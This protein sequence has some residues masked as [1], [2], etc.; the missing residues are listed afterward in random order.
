MHRFRLWWVFPFV[1][2]ALGMVVVAPAVDA[3]TPNFKNGCKST[4][5]PGA[6]MGHYPA[7]PGS[8]SGLRVACIL[9]H[10]NV[11]G[12][13]G[14]FVSSTFTIH[15]FWNALYHNGAGRTMVASL[16][17][18]PGA[19]SFRVA[20]CTSATGWLNRTISGPGIAPYAF[21][22]SITA[23]CD[24]NLNVPIIAP[25]I[26]VGDAFLVE[27]S[28]VRSVTTAMVQPASPMVCD[29]TANFTAAD[30]TLSI[31]GTLIAPG[32]TIT[33]P[34]G[35][36]C[37]D[38][39]TPPTAAAPN[40]LVTIGTTLDGSFPAPQAVTTTRTINDAMFPAM[41]Q[42]SSNAARFFQSDV[43]L[44]VSST[45][46]GEITQPCY[47][48]T[49]VSALLVTLSS[50]CN[51]GVPGIHTVTIG[52]PSRTAPTSADT[53]LNYG[54]Q[55]PLDPTL[56][57]GV[58]PCATDNAG[59]FGVE[60]SWLNPGS[61]VGGVFA[62]QPPGTR[63]V[64]EILFT[65][66]LFQFGAY[67]LEIPAGG[68]VD[69]LVFP[70]HFNVVFPNLPIASALCPSSPTSPGV[71]FSI[72]INATTLSQGAIKTGVGRPGTTQLRSTRGPS[73][74]GSNTTVFITD[75]VNG[76]GVK[77]VGPDFQRTCIIPATT[78]DINF[79]CGDG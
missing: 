22:T 78:P 57:T 8:Q 77:W 27:N 17:S 10:A 16:A 54:V 71:G 6:E 75:D 70:Y 26:G 48:Q 5:T 38:I 30:T 60:G 32:T 79:V 74:I 37:V 15:D 39:S 49:R 14:D 43:G 73:G 59:G 21:V 72:G 53:V 44:R 18:P 58:Q 66:P 23:A 69:P 33:G 50:G 55:L 4:T 68:V 65:T 34:S 47:I 51:N 67:V 7:W 11:A 36:G 52:E 1:L 42:I 3:N 29:P 40:Q 13:P 20:D 9:S 24:V 62:T 63:A 64:G 41:N 46:P 28:S 25:G 2:A 45:V 56:V 61:F 12:G 35:P 31:D 19:L 76:A